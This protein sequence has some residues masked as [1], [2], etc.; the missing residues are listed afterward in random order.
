MGNMISHLYSY[1]EVIGASDTTNFYVAIT[2]N[3]AL[4][5]AVI[6]F[7][8][9]CAKYNREHKTLER[10]IAKIKSDAIEQNKITEELYAR[11]LLLEGTIDKTTKGYKTRKRLNDSGLKNRF[12]EI[13]PFSYRFVVGLIIVLVGTIAAVS[14]RSIV[15]GAIAALLTFGL[16]EIWMEVK[17][18]ANYKA[19]ESESIKFVNLLKNNAYSKSSI[20]EM[21]KATI[22]YIS[23]QLRTNVDKCYYEISSTGNVAKA[24]DDL[25]EKTQYK[26]LRNVFEA[27]K[28]CSVHSED[29]ESVINEATESLSQYIE[30]RGKIANIKRSN[31][32]DLSII[33]GAGV[34]ILFEMKSM[35]S[36]VTIQEV[37]LQRLPG[38]IGL[39]ILA[40]VVIF[41]VYK[42][43]KTEEN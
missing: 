2:L 8:I 24:L 21:F 23:G 1:L 16:I 7:V 5:I 31:L 18:A 12:P 9:F 41:G 10:F 17:I 42:T 26:Q 3:V 39:G 15:A 32:I 30:Y 25:C 35:L 13:T 43:I 14:T 37:L 28:I 20:A 22:P 36:N 19:M 40:G 34:L 6:I 38:Q 33:F 4:A 29:Y 11:Q 27:I